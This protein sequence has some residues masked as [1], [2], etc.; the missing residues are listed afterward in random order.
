LPWCLPLEELAV[1]GTGSTA[2]AVE[3]KI[4]SA[5]AA[6]WDFIQTEVDIGPLWAGPFSSPAGEIV[7]LRGGYT[8]AV[9]LRFGEDLL[10]LHTPWRIRCFLWGTH[11][12]SVELW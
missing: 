4:R 7:V 3:K 12:T 8:F 11:S 2:C 9:Y 5:C 10:V 6:S 1:A